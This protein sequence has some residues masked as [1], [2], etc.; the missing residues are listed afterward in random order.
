MRIIIKL[1]LIRNIIIKKLFKYYFN[2]LQTS[3]K[4]IFIINQFYIKYDVYDNIWNIFCNLFFHNFH[5]K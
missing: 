3:I 2:S 4:N 5:L 1:L